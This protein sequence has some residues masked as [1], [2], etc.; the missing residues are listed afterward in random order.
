VET[1]GFVNVSLRFFFL[2]PSQGSLYSFLE[3]VGSTVGGSASFEL[4]GAREPRARESQKREAASV[5]AML[6][7]WG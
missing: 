5:D 2:P 6:G 1:Q 3:R 4:S 7:Y